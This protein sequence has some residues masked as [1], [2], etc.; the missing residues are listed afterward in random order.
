MPSTERIEIEFSS[1]G[2][3]WPDSTK[4]KLRD[5][6]GG[7]AKVKELEEQLK[8]EQNRDDPDDDFIEDKEAELELAK[9]NLGAMRY[10]AK[11][12]LSRC[13]RRC[14]HCLEM[15]LITDALDATYQNLSGMC[16]R[17]LSRLA[18]CLQSSFV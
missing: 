8:L 17:S 2:Q 3:S 13:R 16:Q 5:R 9:L 14:H 4:T 18:W 12:A 11:L 7:K 6:R 1:D 10:K 15:S